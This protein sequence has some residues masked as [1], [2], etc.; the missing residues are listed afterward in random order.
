MGNPRTPCPPMPGVH[1]YLENR[2]HPPIRGGSD[3]PVF[4]PTVHVHKTSTG[5]VNIGSEPTESD[6]AAVRYNAPLDAPP[7]VPP[8]IRY[9]TIADAMRGIIAKNHLKPGGK[10]AR[11][12]ARAAIHQSRHKK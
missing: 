9:H 12:A 3:P 4:E 7:A 2:L 8:P 5:V 10:L 1:T 6:T 11:R